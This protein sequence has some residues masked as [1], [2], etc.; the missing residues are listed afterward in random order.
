MKKI[1]LLIV[2]MFVII[3]ATTN[4][5]AINDPE[6]L[7]WFSEH[8]Q[9]KDGVSLYGII[10]I[11]QCEEGEG[12]GYGYDDIMWNA[13][14]VYP[15]IMSNTKQIA[16][17]SSKNKY[18]VV[19]TIKNKTTIISLNKVDYSDDWLFERLKIRPLYELRI[20]IYS[21]YNSSC[22]C[23][24]AKKDGEYKVVGFGAAG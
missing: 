18:E 5:E 9:G 7:S 21:G 1:V 17:L 6:F 15:E 11:C 4:A 2:A 20:L 14:N 22:S 24:F 12:E 3:S 16:K 23:Y 8:F 19:K 10:S 13:L